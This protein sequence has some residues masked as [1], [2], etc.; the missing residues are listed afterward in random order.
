[1][2]N[3]LERIEKVKEQFNKNIHGKFSDETDKITLEK[4]F[5]IEEK[6]RLDAVKATVQKMQ[7]Q[8][9]RMVSGTPMIFMGNPPPQQPPPTVK[10]IIT[11]PPPPPKIVT[12][13][14]PVQGKDIDLFLELMDSQTYCGEYGVVV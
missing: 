11:T 2:N 14:P 9:I 3:I 8:P 13:P 1:M 12:P 7:Q 6:V 4:L 5:L 10:K